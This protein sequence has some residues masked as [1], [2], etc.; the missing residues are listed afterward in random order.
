MLTVERSG[1]GASR[2]ID[3]DDILSTDEDEVAGSVATAQATFWQASVDRRRRAT[4]RGP[5]QTV[6]AE[7][8]D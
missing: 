6:C 1:R 2:A 7:A 5:A 4:T 8:D 3:I